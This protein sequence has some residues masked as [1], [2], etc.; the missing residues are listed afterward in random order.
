MEN[1]KLISNFYNAVLVIEDENYSIE[2][3]TRS[4]VQMKFYI[5]DII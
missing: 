1:L 2:E 3:F 4:H 5:R